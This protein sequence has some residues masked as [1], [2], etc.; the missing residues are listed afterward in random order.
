MK[1]LLQKFSGLDLPFIQDCPK[2][3]VIVMRSHFFF[4]FK[5]IYMVIKSAM[6]PAIP[7]KA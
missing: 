6:F 1:T 5:G 7:S 4:G 3:N 2:M